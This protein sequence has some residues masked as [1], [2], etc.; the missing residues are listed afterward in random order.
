MSTFLLRC[1]TNPNMTEGNDICGGGEVIFNTSHQN[2]IYSLSVEHQWL[3][4]SVSLSLTPRLGS[5]LIGFPF[6]K[7]AVRGL[8]RPRTSAPSSTP[9]HSAS[10]WTSGAGSRSSTSP[11]S[12]FSSAGWSPSP[13]YDGHLP[14][15]QAGLLPCYRPLLGVSYPHSSRH[16]FLPRRCESRVRGESMK[17]LLRFTNKIFAGTPS[18][19]SCVMTEPGNM[20]SYQA[21]SGEL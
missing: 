7:C 20:P 16:K 6:R 8:S 9:S 12:P 11:T 19:Q 1:N 21:G 3:C 10:W 5:I 17:Y 14:H 13:L 15:S 2:Y 18:L 4:S